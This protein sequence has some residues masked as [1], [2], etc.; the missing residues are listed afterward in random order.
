MAFLRV[1]LDVPIPELFDYRFEPQTAGASP[2]ECL[3]R[4]VIVPFGLSL[5][6]I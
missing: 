2:E 1:A 6:H 5:I 4:R 3:G